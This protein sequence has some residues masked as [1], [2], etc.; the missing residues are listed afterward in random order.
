MLLE[1]VHHTGHQLVALRV[2][3]VQFEPAQGYDVHSAQVGLVER[4]SPGLLKLVRSQHTT[5]QKVFLSNT[6]S[7]LQSD[8]CNRFI[9]HGRS[10]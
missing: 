1:E 5:K 8:F 10:I 7:N 2:C 4:R 3:A 6:Q 9:S